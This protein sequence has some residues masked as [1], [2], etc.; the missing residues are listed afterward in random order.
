MERVGPGNG[1]A[2]W[3]I[4]NADD[5]GRSD[6]INRGVAR[7]HDQ[8][9]V[10]SASLMVRWPA[11][12]SAAALAR[13][14]PALSVGLH[15]DLG[16]WDFRG[17]EWQPRYTVLETFDDQAAVTDEL[18]AQLERFRVLLGADPTHVDSHQHVH[19]RDA[20]RL[21]I[22]RF[23]EQLHVPLRGAN[24]PI[25]YNGS[26][27]GQSGRGE[28]FPEGISFEALARLLHEQAPGVTELGCHPAD[29]IDIGG[30]YVDERL[31]ELGVLCEPRV[32][33]LLN[34]VGTTLVSF[35]DAPVAFHSAESGA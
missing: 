10:T 24:S 11:A 4:V 7:A 35:R 17:R 32:R 19:L 30:M 27:Y 1:D 22:R 15:I 9:I 31:V 28:P 5:F 14:R 21:P 2:R 20:L 23:A 3:L 16:E 13:D 12:V 26:F 33:A 18:N 29:A 6:G 8:G 25:A 34:D